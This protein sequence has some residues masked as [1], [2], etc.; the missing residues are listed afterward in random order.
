MGTYKVGQQTNVRVLL[1]GASTGCCQ[2]AATPSVK[3]WAP[4][5]RGESAPGGKP[6]Q[7]AEQ[8]SA[9]QAAILG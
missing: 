5:S 8:C 3:A 2:R 6:L 1:L 4:A 7:P 9:G